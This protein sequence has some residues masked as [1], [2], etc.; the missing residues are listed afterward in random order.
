MRRSRTKR[1]W[2]PFHLADPEKR[3]TRLDDE[4]LGRDRRAAVPTEEA[5]RG[6]VL[7]TA[8]VIDDDVI[9]RVQRGRG[10]ER[11]GPRVEVDVVRV[12]VVRAA[13]AEVMRLRRHEDA[14]GRRGKLRA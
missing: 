5:L 1:A 2:G 13:A 14:S 12:E 4:R 3:S 7:D 8:A 10:R 11:V 9:A 6:V